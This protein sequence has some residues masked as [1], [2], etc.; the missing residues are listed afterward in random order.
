MQQSLSNVLP[1][2]EEAANRTDKVYFVFDIEAKD[3]LYLSPAFEQLWNES[4]E[5][6]KV[7][8]NPES[9]LDT[10]HPED[11]EYLTQIYHEIISGQEKKEMEFRIRL[12]EENNRWV[13][14]NPFFI[15]K[16]GKRVILGHAEDY[17]DRKDKNQ[18]MQTFAAKKD[19]IMEILAH[20]LAG[21]LSNIKGLATVVAQK[22]KGK[23]HP[24]LDKL[25]GMIQETS[26][27]SIRLIREFVKV[28]FLQSE[29]SEL[30]KERVDIVDKMK[31]VLGQYEHSEHEVKKKFH[32]N[33]SEEP[34]FV[35]IDVYK[36]TQVLNNLISNAIKFTGDDG[37]ITITLEDRQDTFFVS[38]ADNGIGIPAKYHENLF[39]RF[40]HARRKGLKGE[41]STGLG[42]SIIKTIVEWHNGKIWFESEVNKGSTFFIELPKE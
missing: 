37:E 36:F 9:L 33:I 10:V 38:V 27:R 31:E 30:V 18:N 4:V 34:I 17:S 29:N 41:P 2:F 42:M 15:E 32:F 8:R 1:F 28:E 35:R 24:D 20:D 40:T 13:L 11:K 3:F 16:G 22:L 21:P 5:V 19:S 39:D 6:E 14:V 23:E 7:H 25:V 12:S 26:E